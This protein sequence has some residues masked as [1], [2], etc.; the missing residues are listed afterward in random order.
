MNHRL[1]GHRHS[2]G[3]FVRHAKGLAG[4]VLVATV[5]CLGTSAAPAHA[6]L[7][8]TVRNDPDTQANSAAIRAFIDEQVADLADPATVSDARRKLIDELGRGPSDAFLRAY[9]ATIA[10]PLRTALSGNDKLVAVN[11][12]I[13]LDAVAAR[14][15]S[16]DLLEPTLVAVRSD[17]QA[18]AVHGIRAAEG[19]LPA[20]VS[21]NVRQPDGVTLI[22]E[23]IAA[24]DRFVDEPAMLAEVHKSL[25][26]GIV[27]G[28]SLLNGDR[29]LKA[30]IPLLVDGVL[31]LLE[32]RI[33]MYV[34]A[35][36]ATTDPELNAA[37]FLTDK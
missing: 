30:G 22:D 9:A 33:P 16:G 36:P 5:C 24:A 19:V 4:G 35:V 20:L 8:E 15:L 37:L 10:G 25:Q 31:Q 21:V 13:V 27:S 11:A 1:A 7:S 28:P 12:A 34:D 3:S 32:K 2:R 17:N 6:Q 14:T 18:I 23:L 26:V 29:N